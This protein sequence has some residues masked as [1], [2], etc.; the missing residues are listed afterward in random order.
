M[1]KQIIAK[2]GAPPKGI[3]S[4]AIMA[5]GTMLFVSGQAP[6][7][8][9]GEFQLGRFAEQAKL[10]FDNVTK[11]L[12]AGG[13]SWADVVRVGVFLADLANFAEMN[14][15]YQTYVTEPYPARTT[16]QAGLPAGMEIEVDCIAVIPE[17]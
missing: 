10:T 4:P 11:L 14:E 7:D 15:I 8:Q 2:T 6:V 12:E 9:A 13:A 1:R 17:A 16:V 3:Y 5:T